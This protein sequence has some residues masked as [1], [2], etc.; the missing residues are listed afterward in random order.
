ML[1]ALKLAFCIE[2]GL[3][4]TSSIEKGVRSMRRSL[5]WWNSI[6]DLALKQ[7]VFY[8]GLVCWIENKLHFLHAEAKDICLCRKGYICLGLL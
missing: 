2:S 8:F 1:P 7:G 3:C 4:F 6:Y 5:Q